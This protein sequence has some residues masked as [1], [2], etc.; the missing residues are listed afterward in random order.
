MAGLEC[1]EVGRICLGCAEFK[2]WGNFTKAAKGHNGRA[3]RCRDCAKAYYQRN[4]AVIAERTA[5][6]YKAKKSSIIAYVRKHYQE[7]RAEILEK[8]KAYRATPKAKEN[9]KRFRN[10]PERRMSNAIRCGIRKALKGGRKSE[11]TWKMLGY[12]LQ[13]FVEHIERQFVDGM[14]WDNYGQWHIDHI[15]PVTS[16]SHLP[17]NEC[18]K[19]AWHLPNLRPLW[20]LENMRKNGKR[21]FLL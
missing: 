9:D 4:R 5:K 6:R 2:C 17:P 13:D 21:L 1:S 3:S 15:V 11:P 8:Q 19:R 10:R 16:F 18:V 14:S 7:N 20:A 12:S